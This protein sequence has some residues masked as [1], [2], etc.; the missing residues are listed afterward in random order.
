VCD[1][2]DL[3][4]GRYDQLVTHGAHAEPPLHFL[5]DRRK[6]CFPTAAVQVPH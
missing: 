6:Q 1:P 4:A 2:R 3:D 5:S